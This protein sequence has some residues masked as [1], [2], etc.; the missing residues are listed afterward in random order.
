MT[1]MAVSRQV[2]V[3]TTTQEVNLFFPRV[4]DWTKYRVNPLVLVTGDG[5]TLADDVKEF[6]S[7]G[8]P[9]DLY[10]V[11]RSL[12]FFEEQVQHWAALDTEESVWFAEHCNPKVEPKQMVNRHTIGDTLGG[13]DFAWE[14]VNDWK[15]EESKRFFI[16]NTAYFA[17]LTSF[18]MGYEKVVLAGC[19][20]DNKAHFYEPSGMVGPEWTGMMYCQWMD[21][22]MKNKNA[23]LVK[24]MGGYSAFILGQATK[25]WASVIG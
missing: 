15:R 20:L 5:H 19:P 3:I 7:W 9:Y 17:V 13:Y 11:N 24:S 1:P 2:G 16:G 25:E 6:K 21:F 12:I 18:Y 10:C 4:D 23:D 8:I 22:K 14:Q